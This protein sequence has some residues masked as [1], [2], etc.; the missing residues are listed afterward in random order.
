MYRLGDHIHFDLREITVDGRKTDMFGDVREISNIF[1][2]ETFSVISCLH[3][4]EHLYLTDAIKLIRDCYTILKPGGELLLEGPDVVKLAE[5]YVGDAQV[6]IEYFY[7]DESKRLGQWGDVMMHKWGWTADLIV[8]AM[9]K[10]NFQITYR[11]EDLAFRDSH[12][13]F[14]V[15]GVKQ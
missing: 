15:R 1:K 11:G 9:E 14:S 3:V 4:I 7:G 6:L 12:R 5:L 2:P 10:Q 8:A 13:D